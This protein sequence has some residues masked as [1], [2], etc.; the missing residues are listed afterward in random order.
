M[1]F[2]I[3]RYFLFA[4]R[5]RHIEKYATN[6][7]LL[8]LPFV[9]LI[10]FLVGYILVGI[11]GSHDLI[12]AGILFGGS[13]F[14]FLLLTI[15][16]YIVSKIREQEHQ[17]E[18]RYEETEKEVHELSSAAITYFRVN[19]TKNKIL[20]AGGT[21]LYDTDKSAATYD[22]MLEARQ[23]YLVSCIS[24]VGASS[25]RRGDLLDYFAHGH[26]YS[27]EVIL[28][29]REGK[30][31]SFMIFKA[32]LAEEPS[33][34]DVIAF[35]VEEDYNEKMILETIL[36]R[37][38]SFRYDIVCSIIDGSYHL[39][40]SGQQEHA[41]AIL[42][43]QEEGAYDVFC[44]D[45]VLPRLATDADP[46]E[47]MSSLDLNEVAKALE[48]ATSYE[49]DVH[50]R[51]GEQNYFKRFT[52]YKVTSD[53]AF[54]VLL[55]QDTTA[56]HRE[57]SLQNEKLSEALEE[58][59]KA[60]E[61]KTTF[62]A[63]MSHDIRTPMN[64]I[65]GFT[66]LAKEEQDV[67]KI[68]QYLAKIETSSSH[69]IS[70]IDDVLEMSRIESGKSGL[71]PSKTCLRDLMTEVRD[72]F[73]VTMENKGISFDARLDGVAH[74]GVLV[75]AFRL[76]RILL[77][78]LSNAYKFTP[79]GGEVEALIRELPCDIDD[80]GRYQ[81]IVRDT[82][83]GMSEEFAS[84]VFEAYEREKKST[85]N[86]IQGTGLGM[87]IT[88]TIVDMMGGK[89]EVSSK[90]GQGTTFTVTLDLPIVSKDEM[91]NQLC[92]NADAKKE[93]VEYSFEGKRILVAD[94]NDINRE[95]AEVL[96][97]NIGFTVENAVDGKQAC[98]MVFG[99]E[100]GYYDAVLM[101]VQMPVLD[102]LE[103]TRKIRL[104]S[105]PGIAAI[106]II[107]FTA[108]AFEEDIQ[109]S[110]KAGMNAHLRKPIDPEAMYQVLHEILSQK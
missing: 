61:A 44:R 47:V 57:R 91:M 109:E 84:R 35:L 85:V 18:L 74:P 78:L 64:A 20:S 15:L 6:P 76:K 81:I 80:F 36:N 3:I 8:Y 24:R 110:L 12:V 100:A 73:T 48:K 55:V 99:H 31:A 37:A 108:N 68:H 67:E 82:G 46:R 96:L 79:N 4:R 88:K 14:V 60:N 95:I 58:A 59:R 50:I 40:A 87:A 13:V 72:M 42:P 102:G 54:F 2:N 98:D 29:K 32:T 101:D 9:L 97:Q 7:V 93:M 71:L 38:M 63:N 39:I 70:L 69:L 30:E 56:I 66:A 25:F 65:T 21:E 92:S 83:V 104:H 19:L 49:S 106:P 23:P 27:S 62:F 17:A 94:D 107:A 51:Y 77:N 1:V 28:V 103:A 86:Q 105:E 10:F 33:S 5:L 16:Y 89:I 52:F 41:K 11:F 26:N 34:H 43:E 75:D 22:E 90:E 45:H 53:V